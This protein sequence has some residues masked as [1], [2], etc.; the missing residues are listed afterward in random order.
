MQPFTT[1]AELVARVEQYADGYRVLGRAPGGEPVVAATTGG[2][3]EPAV[4]ITAGAHA[5]EQAGVSA[6]VELLDE[7]DTEHRVH[8]LPTR[9]PVGL[10]GYPYALGLALGE[11]P[12]VRSHDDV[13][14]LLADEGELVHREDDFVLALVGEY[15]FAVRDPS[16]EGTILQRLKEYTET[17]PD[18]LTPLRGRRIFT[19]PSHEGVEGT[20]GLERAYT[21]VVD[22]DGMPLHLNRF[23]GTEWA[24][25]ESR[26][27]TRL[28]E[29]VRPGLTF[30]N[31]ETTGHG[32]RY[33]VSL[34]PQRTEAGDDREA[35]IALA[36]TAAVEAS[37]VT[38]ATDE[39]VVSEPTKTVA[40]AD[41]PPDEPFYTRAGP[42]AYWVDPNLTSPPRS[43]EGLNATDYAAEHYG[44]AYTLE[45]GM[46]GSF[47]ER[48]DAAVLSVRT[49][50]REFE[51]AVGGD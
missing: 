24:P 27:V 38:L 34:R 16:T 29:E 41:D 12:R 21:L 28:A 10:N 15:G 23:L 22:P 17:R 26:C 13:R 31:H 44:L 45:T 35:E 32:A 2:E 8:V 7:L 9:D 14:S 47:E 1:N 25:V 18:V 3:R 30:D 39:D 19:T 20:E 4:L 5:T 43:G 48:V 6:A 50:V 11:E 49:G 33:H 46:Y 36:I 37:G 40:Y 51:R 42:G